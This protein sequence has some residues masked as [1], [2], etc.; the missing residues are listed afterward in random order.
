MSVTVKYP[1]STGTAFSRELLLPV[2]STAINIDNGDP[3]LTA[4][5]ASDIGEEENH[6]AAVVNNWAEIHARYPV[7]SPSLDRLDRLDECGSEAPVYRI[8]I[9]GGPCGGMSEGRPL[10]RFAP[11]GGAA[12]AMR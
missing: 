4:M 8:V 9:S 3:D 1:D 11:A 2:Q 7:R 6:A 5:S 10:Q 12:F